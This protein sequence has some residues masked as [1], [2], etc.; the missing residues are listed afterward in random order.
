VLTE[1]LGV[2]G[3]LIEKLKSSEFLTLGEE[4]LDLDPPE[5]LST[6]EGKGRASAVFVALYTLRKSAQTIEATG[7][8]I[9]DLIALGRKGDRTALKL[10]I[11]HDPLA[12]TC[13]TVAAEIL[14]SELTDNGKFAIEIRNALR[15]P[16][17]FNKVK[18]GLLRYVI[19]LA[20]EDGILEQMSEDIRYEF[21]CQKLNLYP[22][23]NFEAKD[24][25]NRF[26]REQVKTF[27]S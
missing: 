7:Q 11:R 4:D 26:V 23:R 18:H 15:S 2:S 24:S 10:A 25:F 12:L 20:H 13:P 21:F 22:D 14:K 17:D 6:E 9:N 19:R 16:R 8:S 3:H 5:W 27:R 1:L